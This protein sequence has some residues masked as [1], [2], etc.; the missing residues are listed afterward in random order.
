MYV[1]VH[2][3][4]G[5][6]RCLVKRLSGTRLAAHGDAVYANVMR[7]LAANK[8]RRRRTRSFV[9]GVVGDVRPSAAVGGKLALACSSQWC[10]NDQPVL[11]LLQCCLRHIAVVLESC[12]SLFAAWY[13]D[14]V[15]VQGVVVPGCRLSTGQGRS[16]TCDVQGV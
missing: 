14:G 7:P 16:T 3:N 12:C 1:C 11:H 10:C 4:F 6:S 15:G 2:R 8:V 5:P 13:A 9:D